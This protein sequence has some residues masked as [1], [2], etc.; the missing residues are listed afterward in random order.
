MGAADESCT[1]MHQRVRRAIAA[2]LAAA[3][4]APHDDAAC[5][6]AIRFAGEPCLTARAMK[7]PLAHPR[8]GPASAMAGAAA[9]AAGR[10]NAEPAAAAGT[11]SRAG[12]P[13]EPR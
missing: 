11:A 3:Q 4:S 5:Q 6:R 7:M 8:P 12:S 9:V 13:A 10:R 1:K 2:A